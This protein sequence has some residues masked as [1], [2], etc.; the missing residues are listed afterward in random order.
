MSA[1]ACNHVLKE[2]V[3]IKNACKRFVPVRPTLCHLN[4]INIATGSAVGISLFFFD[5]VRCTLRETT[6]HAK[7]QRTA[8]I[9]HLLK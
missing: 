1:L 3:V 6:L 2:Y 7:A 8:A 5:V 9:L 4:R